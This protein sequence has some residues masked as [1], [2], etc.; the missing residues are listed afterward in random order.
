MAT[1]TGVRVDTGALAVF[2][3]LV[4][5]TGVL[6]MNGDDGGV[7]AKMSYVWRNGN[8]TA[9]AG[10]LEL[11]DGIELSVVAGVLQPEVC[12]LAT[13]PVSESR[14]CRVREIGRLSPVGYGSGMAG[15]FLGG[16][17]CG[18]WNCEYGITLPSP[19]WKGRGSVLDSHGCSNWSED[20]T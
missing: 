10:R 13:W 11:G 4:Y 14:R 7:S 17:S 2:V 20:K 1:V 19:Q 16:W 18:Y 3:A 12:D 9:E 5:S 6:G 8:G 15:S